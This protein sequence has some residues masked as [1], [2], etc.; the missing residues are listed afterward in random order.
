M[1]R[2]TLIAYINWNRARLTISTFATKFISKAEIIQRITAR[3]MH[4]FT[5]NITD[6]K[7]VT[8]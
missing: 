3:Q 5:T 8:Y 2:V 6:Y 7:R 1:I 4:T